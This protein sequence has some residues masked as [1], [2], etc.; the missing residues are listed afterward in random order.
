M[1]LYF[2]KESELCYPISVHKDIMRFDEISELEVFEAKRETGTGYFFC[3]EFLEVGEVGEGC[4][5]QCDS[6][7]PRNGKNGRCKHSGSTYEQ[8]EILKK[9]KI[10]L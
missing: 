5:K 2:A 6:Y 3:T 4:G 9:L 1:K 8:T 10:K 7:K